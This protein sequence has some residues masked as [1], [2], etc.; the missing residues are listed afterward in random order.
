MNLVKKTYVIP[1][2]CFYEPRRCFIMFS[3]RQL[4]LA[5]YR[6]HSKLNYPGK[7]CILKA[8][9]L[10]MEVKFDILFRHLY[11]ISGQPNTGWSDL[12]ERATLIS[13]Q[14]KSWQTSTVYTAAVATG[15]MKIQL[16]QNDKYSKIK[17]LITKTQVTVGQ[18]KVQYDPLQFTFHSIFF[19][20]RIS[21]LGFHKE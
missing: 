8:K 4:S 17:T 13:S 19:L 20:L 9:P 11:L 10:G 15:G 6:T 12:S 5:I 3:G 14:G 7:I 16:K 2:V 18:P 1:G 21:H